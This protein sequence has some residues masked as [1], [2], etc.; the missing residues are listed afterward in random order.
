MDVSN[1][2][3]KGSG[4]CLFHAI[5]GCLSLRKSSDKEAPFYPCRY[6]RRAVVAHMAHQRHKVMKHKG[7]ALRSTYGIA[8]NELSDTPLSYKQYL[9]FLLKSTTWGEDIVIYAISDLFRLKITSINTVRLDEYRCRHN[10]S[11]RDVDAVLIFNGS[12]HYSY[13][14]KWSFVLVTG[15][16][17][18]AFVVNQSFVIQKVHGIF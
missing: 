14:G 5:R 8:N 7:A 15:R 4:N 6:L 10:Q 16:L 13:A 11:L 1:L 9:Q 18:W 3:T 2:Q 12:N 17:R